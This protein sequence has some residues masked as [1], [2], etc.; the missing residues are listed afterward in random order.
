MKKS[1]PQMV[2]RQPTA[3]S[4]ECPSTS[5]KFVETAGV[6]TAECAAVFCCWPCGLIDL[7]VTAFVKLPAGLCRRAIRN[8]QRKRRV[9]RLCALPRRH[10]DEYDLRI[11]PVDEMMIPWLPES[12]PSAVVSA[13]EKEMWA[14]FCNTGF[15]RNPSAREMKFFLFPETKMDS[16]GASN[17]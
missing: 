3:L 8:N 10:D 9:K 13:F 17:E 7:V 12:S 4:R 1:A 2:M 6:T 11:H 14:E 5:S 16:I 15:W